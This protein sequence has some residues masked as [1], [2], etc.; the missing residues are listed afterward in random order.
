M[1][2][3]GDG[4]HVDVR[5]IIIPLWLGVS[6]TAGFCGFI[7]TG[8]LAYWQLSTK[9]D[10]LIVNQSETWTKTDMRVWCLEAERANAAK[11]WVCPGSPVA[12][13]PAPVRRLAAPRMSDKAVVAPSWFK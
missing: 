11:G 9:V 4:V 6:I 5:N 8:V 13:A 7:T 12:S 1:T 2:R 10:L 3:R